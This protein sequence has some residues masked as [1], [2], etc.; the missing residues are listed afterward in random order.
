MKNDLKQENWG[1]MIIKP[2]NIEF[3]RGRSNGLL[4]RLLY[5]LE[6]DQLY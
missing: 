4:V 2:Q 3:W 5:R 6:N 1:G